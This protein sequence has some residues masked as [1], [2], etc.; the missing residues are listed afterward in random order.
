MSSAL[1][2]VVTPPTAG[3]TVGLEFVSDTVEMDDAGG[4]DDIGIAIGI[5]IAVGEVE[6]VRDAII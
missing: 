6:R 3:N 4:I 2:V 1:S 5:G